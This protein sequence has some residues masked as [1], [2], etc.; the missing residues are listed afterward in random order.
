MES[1]WTLRDQI[2]VGVVNNKQTILKRKLST[3]KT[4]TIL[5]WRLST[6]N[7]DHTEMGVDNNK[8]RPY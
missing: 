4:E 6:I 5:E 2:E 1:K 8:Q 7:R 3:K